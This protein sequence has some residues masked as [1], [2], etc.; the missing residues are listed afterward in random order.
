MADVPAEQSGTDSQAHARNLKVTLRS[1]LQI[2][3]Q[4]YQGEA[5]YVVHDPVSFRSH[6][7]SVFQYDVFT[8]MAPGRTLGENFERFAAQGAF[9]SNEEP[10]FFELISSF[11]RLGLI[12]MPVQNG[13]RLF[14]QH[15]KIRASKRRGKLLGI[16]FLQIPLVN[17]DQFLARTANCV[18]WMFTK[19]FFCVWLAGMAAAGMVLL[20]RAG[21]LLQPLNGILATNNLPF[22]WLAFVVLKIWHEL[23]HGYA[24]RVFGGHVPEMGSILIAGTP[25]AYVDASAAWSFPERYRRLI[26]M[27]GG[28][29]FESLVFILCVFV[30]AFASSP[31]LASCAYQLFVMASLVTL[32][33]NANPLMKFDGYFIFSELIGIQNLRPRADAQIKRIL[34]SVLVGVKPAATSD[35]PTTKALLVSYGISAVI[36]KFFLVI[37][38]AALV[39]TKFPLIGLALAAFYILTTVGSGVLKMAKYLLKSKETKPVRS[40]AR[41]VAAVVLIGLPL[42][43]CIVPVPFGVVTQGIVGAQG[44]HFLNVISPGHFESSLVTAGHRVRMGTPVVRLT[45]ERLQEDVRIAKSSL[46]DAT[47]RWKMLQTTDQAA[48]QQQKAVVDELRKQ[49]AESDALVNRLVLSAPGDGTVVRL[50][51]DSERGSFLKEGTPL[52]IIAHGAPVLRTWLNEDQLGSI[53]RESGTEVT[54]RIPGRST[55]THTATIVNVEPAAEN[56]FR[57][58]ALTYIAGGEILVNPTTGVPLEPLFQIDLQPQDD[59]LALTEYGSRISLNIPRRY[60][61]VAAWTVRKCVRFVQ[62]LLAA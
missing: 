31:L 41:L 29:F 34:T 33:F 58:D 52:A 22:L 57:T 50:V 48:A 45:N 38:I 10:V 37:S 49:A 13:A 61:S 39:A 44:E 14:E 40:R 6:R 20:S 19:S 51:P 4:V 26:V 15:E 1:D 62:E 8:G 28:M 36:Y 42:A 24:C 25:A 12:V 23:G 53:L 46:A 32:L 59:V 17:P 2:S 18:R 7:L 16:L 3:R 5:V 21:D 47:L 35:S 9:A 43:A 11:A 55:S 30:W 27:C 54:F 60:E 56:V